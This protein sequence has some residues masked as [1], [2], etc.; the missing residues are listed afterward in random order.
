[1]H[2]R[3]P[4]NDWGES[5]TQTLSPVILAETSF[6]IPDGY[7]A[8]HPTTRGSRLRVKAERVSAAE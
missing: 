5:V 4:S 3:L 7:K 1:M 6:S 8:G 2:N